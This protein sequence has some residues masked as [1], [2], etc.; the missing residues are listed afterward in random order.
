MIGNANLEID[1]VMSD[2]LEILS[3]SDIYEEKE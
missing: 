1:H 2:E 3:T